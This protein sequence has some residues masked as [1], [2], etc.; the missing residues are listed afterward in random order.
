MYEATDAT[1][2]DCGYLPRRRHPL[3]SI[4][5]QRAMPSVGLFAES[6]MK[7]VKLPSSTFSPAC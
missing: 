3:A 7:I 4:P 1:D 5:E 6:L 2:T